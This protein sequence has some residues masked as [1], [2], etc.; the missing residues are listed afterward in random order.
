MISLYNK[1]NDI[2]P[3]HPQYGAG[4]GYTI[5]ITGDSYE[6]NTLLKRLLR[7]QREQVLSQS[8]GVSYRLG[9]Y[10][11]DT[12]GLHQVSGLS[13]QSINNNLLITVNNAKGG[14]KKTDTSQWAKL[15]DAVENAKEKSIVILMPK[16]VYTLEENEKR[17]FDAVLA[18]AVEKGKKVYVR[19]AQ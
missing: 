13:A 3:V 9:D 11:G 8:G 17:V 7:M 2:G 4:N 1:P 14:I 16:S 12:D 6:E 18:D 15:I 10:D 5:C 19:W